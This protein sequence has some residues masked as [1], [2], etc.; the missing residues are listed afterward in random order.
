MDR[1]F[2]I[3]TQKAPR[4]APISQAVGKIFKKA[5]FLFQFC[6]GTGGLTS[7]TT[8]HVDIRSA[9]TIWLKTVPKRTKRHFFCFFGW[10]T[11]GVDVR[12]GKTCWDCSPIAEL[13][14]YVGFYENSSDGPSTVA[15]FLGVRVEP[16][17]SWDF[18]GPLPKNKT[19]PKFSDAFS[20]SEFN[21]DH[22]FV[23]KFGLA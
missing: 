8:S 17:K 13:Q 19:P 10:G 20:D 18:G 15:L 6:N 1:F 22:D 5:C 11:A 7:F 21:A 9:P 4:N 14:T 16:A 23:I 12:R 2:L 3:V